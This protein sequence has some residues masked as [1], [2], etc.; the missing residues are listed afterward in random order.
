VRFIHSPHE[1]VN[2][3]SSQL[4]LIDQLNL[5]AFGSPSINPTKVVKWEIGLFTQFFSSPHPVAGFFNISRHRIMNS[6]MKELEDINTFEIDTRILA[7][8]SP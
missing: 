8:S 3:W 5:P 1:G 4:D 7:V 2:A 6:L